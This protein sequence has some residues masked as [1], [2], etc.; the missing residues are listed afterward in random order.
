MDADTSQ[1]FSYS[2]GKLAAIFLWITAIA[3]I[4]AVLASFLNS[5]FSNRAQAIA[6]SRTKSALR[7]LDLA[8]SQADLRIR[9][10][11]EQAAV[12]EKGAAD[13]GKRAAEANERAAELEL[14]AARLNL[15]LKKTVREVI[16]RVVT[17]EQQKVFTSQIIGE[18]HPE[19]MIRHAN[20]E[21]SSNFARSIGYALRGA[22]AEVG[23][24]LP[25]ESTYSDEAKDWFPVTV[26]P[27]KRPYETDDGE[28][29]IVK[30]LLSS[31]IVGA[32]DDQREAHEIYYVIDVPMRAARDVGSMNR[33]TG[34]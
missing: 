27:P 2:A 3:G 16:G 6:E 30:A 5:V 20:D 15:E 21:E 26:T 29:P 24:A 25:Y 19:F 18:Y 14:K 4:A 1:F 31:G 10:A 12:A 33:P 22:G 17:P 11:Q 9:Q 8:R 28:D 13:A 7:E 34:P 23:F 32:V